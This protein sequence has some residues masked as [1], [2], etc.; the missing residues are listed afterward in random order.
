MSERMLR[1]TPGYW[2]LTAAAANPASRASGGES[3]ARWTWPME[4]AAMG[5]GE[6]PSGPGRKRRERQADPAGP[7]G[8]AASDAAPSG[9]SGSGGGGPTDPSAAS[10]ARSSCSCGMK[11][12]DARAMAKASD[13]SRGT[14]LGSWREIICGGEGRQRRR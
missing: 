4:A 6:K 12:A 1:A 8:P 7:A 14:V 11:S 10:R 2:T 9:A 3:V 13:T 5:R